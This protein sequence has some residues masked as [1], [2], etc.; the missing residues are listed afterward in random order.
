VWV[1][2]G[3]TPLI[4][5]CTR[6]RRVVA[7]WFGYLIPGQ[8]ALLERLAGPQSRSGRCGEEESVCS[9]SLHARGVCRFYT[10]TTRLVSVKASPAAT[11]PTGRGPSSVA[12]VLSCI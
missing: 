10:K 6:C 5:I 4:F 8:A 2:G 9:R 3:I 7:S 12:P 1:S 11:L